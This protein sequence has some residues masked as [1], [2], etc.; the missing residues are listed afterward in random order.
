MKVERFETRGNGLE[1]KSLGVPSLTG[2]PSTTVPHLA[3]WMNRSGW[4]K[5]VDPT[6]QPPEVEAQP[7]H[8]YWGDIVAAEQGELGSAPPRTASRQWD[9]EIIAAALRSER[10][11]AE[12]DAVLARFAQGGWGTEVVVAAVLSKRPLHDIDTLLARFFRSTWS[13]R[14]VAAAIASERGLDEIDLLLARFGLA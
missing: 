2:N 12:L 5:A 7:Q 8:E 10:P 9:P 1:A 6:Q 3:P 14:L 11:L 13:A 4:L